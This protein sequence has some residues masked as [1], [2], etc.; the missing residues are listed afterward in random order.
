MHGSDRLYVSDFSQNNFISDGLWNNMFILT[1]DINPP[2]QQDIIFF[3][4]V[5][6]ACSINSYN[7]TERSLEIDSGSSGIKSNIKQC[8]HRTQSYLYKMPMPLSEVQCRTK[9][10]NPR[11]FIMLSNNTLRVR[12]TVLTVFSSRMFSQFYPEHNYE[13]GIYI[14]YYVH[15]L[16]LLWNWWKDIEAFHIFSI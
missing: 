8:E 14:P 4:F 2:N 15:L 1:N 9:R 3:R 11:I 12:H 16:F 7:I 6:N 10:R 13:M 5:E